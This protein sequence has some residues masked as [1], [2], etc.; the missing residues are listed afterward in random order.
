MGAALRT[1]VAVTAL[2]GLFPFERAHAV[3]LAG[4]W[5]SDTVRRW[6]VGLAVLSR[7]WR[8]N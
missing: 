4:T 1:M 3:D 7:S 2:S 8:M 5:A 6:I